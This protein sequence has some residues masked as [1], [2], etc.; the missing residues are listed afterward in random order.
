MSSTTE[1]VIEEKFRFGFYD[2]AGFLYLIRV[3]N[4]F[5]RRQALR[6]TRFKLQLTYICEWVQ[7]ISGVNPIKLKIL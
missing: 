4:E 6:C 1:N 3:L 7:Y 2:M 5:G